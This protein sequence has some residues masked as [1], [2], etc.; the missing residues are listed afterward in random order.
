MEEEDKKYLFFGIGL[1]LI[2]GLVFV[3]WILPLTPAQATFYNVTN[4]SF[5]ATATEINTTHKVSGTNTL[6]LVIC[7]GEGQTVTTAKFQNV[8]M[9]KIK[10]SRAATS[11]V[12]VW[13][14]VG[15]SG[16]GQASCTGLS[17]NDNGG[18]V[19]ISYTGVNQ[20]SPFGATANRTATASAIKFNLT[21]TF[22][23]SLIVSAITG[24]GGDTF[25]TVDTGSGQTQRKKF[26][27]GTSTTAD[28]GYGI[29]EKSAPIAGLSNL[30]YTMS[31]SDV[32]TIVGLELKSTD[33]TTPKWSANST[34]ATTAGT[35]IKHNLKWTDNRGLSGYIFSFDNGTGTFVN[36]SWVSLKGTTNYTNVTKGVSTTI[37][38]NIRWRVWA[39]DTSDN[40]N[41]TAIFSYLTTSASSCAYGG[42]GAWNVLCSDNCS[43]TSN[44][45]LKGNAIKITGTGSF[46]TTANIYNWSS[47]YIRGTDST[48]RCNVYCLAGGCFKK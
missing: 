32:Y 43:I 17:S 38:A 7:L 6:L 33:T 30:N 26:R 11:M 3:V 15:A 45:N 31:V 37:G 1:F 16:S 19:A 27:S 5:S 20:T 44:V 35:F 10:E 46:K 24:R 12:S 28:T 36:N 48:N 21:T 47:V 14:K 9:T 13:Y 23:D 40:W 4:N 34:N 41:S 2:L 42:S 25:P 22:T 39:N 29:G 18:I 8:A